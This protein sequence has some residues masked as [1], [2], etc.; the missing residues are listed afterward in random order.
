MVMSN[1]QCKD[2]K[3]GSKMKTYT[4]QEIA[5]AV[6]E[7]LSKLP[8]EDYDKME[9]VFWQFKTILEGE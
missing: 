7:T 2:E 9:A 6:Y 1:V 4:I 5:G 8:V 3:G